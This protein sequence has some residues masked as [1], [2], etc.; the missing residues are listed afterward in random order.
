VNSP[1]EWAW[2]EELA[3]EQPEALPLVSAPPYP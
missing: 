3:R 1:R 2:A